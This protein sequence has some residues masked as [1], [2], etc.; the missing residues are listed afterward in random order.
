MLY[1]VG[2]GLGSVEDI[3][4]KG[5][6][7]VKNAKRVYLEAYTSILTV[8]KAELVCALVCLGL[9]SAIP[10]QVQ[11]YFH[12]FDDKTTALW[13][14]FVTFLKLEFAARPYIISFIT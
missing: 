12:K 5:L 3:T 11:I 1:F 8:G 14:A 2:L 9:S 4:V 10:H 13:R 6:R 7:I